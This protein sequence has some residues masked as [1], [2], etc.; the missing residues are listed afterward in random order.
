MTDRELWVAVF[1]TALLGALGLPNAP[2]MNGRP[3]ALNEYAKALADQALKDAPED[4][5]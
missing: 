3:V 4:K 2:H 1:N 5:Q